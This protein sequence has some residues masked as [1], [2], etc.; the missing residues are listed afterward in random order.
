MSYY[1]DQEDYDDEGQQG[2]GD[3]EQVYDDVEEPF[4]QLRLNESEFNGL[5]GNLAGDFL[6]NRL[7]GGGGGDEEGG[8]GGGAD[9]VSNFLG[10]G[11]GGGG[12]SGKSMDLGDLLGSLAGQAISGGGGGGGHQQ[13][14]KGSGLEGLAGKLNSSSFIILKLLK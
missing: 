12:K 7:S 6:K 14:Q 5:I 11:G 13:P 1:R 2:G 4:T 9:F 8:G 3:D 10:G